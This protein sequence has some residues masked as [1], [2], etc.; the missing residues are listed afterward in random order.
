SSDLTEFQQ[1][2]PRPPVEI[3]DAQREGDIALDNGLLKKDE[4]PPL[5][6]FIFWGDGSLS[7]GKITLGMPDSHEM[8]TIQL[9]A[10]AGGIRVL[11]HDS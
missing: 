10:G 2:M 1:E 5:A 9:H 11:N 6:R 4:V 7:A 3:M 8:L